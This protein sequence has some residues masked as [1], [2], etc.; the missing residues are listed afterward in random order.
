M[1]DESKTRRLPVIALM[2][3]AVLTLCMLLLAACGDD[4]DGTG[5]SPTDQASESPSGSAEPSGSVVKTPAGTEGAPPECTVEDQQRGLL[6]FLDIGG[7]EGDANFEPGEPVEIEMRLVN[8]GD[9]DSTLHFGTTQ[10]YR[11][12]IEQMTG[13]E[14]GPEVWSSDDGLVYDQVQGDEVIE[15]NTTVVYTET[16]DQLDRD[17]AQVAE[18][19]Y[20]VSA[21]SI[22]CG[23]A[24]QTNCQFG[25]VRQIVIASASPTPTQPPTS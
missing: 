14:T 10:R 16:W 24:G 20:K 2:A 18:G 17:G 5:G 11:F 8:C 4:D 6:A 25:S 21:F 9:A 7:E 1:T 13:A 15:P 3:A 19:T 12:F 22:G 23:Q